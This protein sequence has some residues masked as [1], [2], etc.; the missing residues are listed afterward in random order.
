[1][2]WHCKGANPSSCIFEVAPY[3]HTDTQTRKYTSVLRKSFSENVWKTSRK[4]LQVDATLAKQLAK[5]SYFAAFVFLK[6]FESLWNNFYMY[7]LHRDVTVHLL[8]VPIPIEENLTWYYLKILPLSLQN[9]FCSW[10]IWTIKY[11][12]KYQFPTSTL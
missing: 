9:P 3:P 2:S 1:M 6:I 5:N 10:I 7:Y 8:T 12:H 11:I 4:Y